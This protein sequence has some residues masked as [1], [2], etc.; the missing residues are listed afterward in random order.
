[1]SKKIV[2][3]EIWQ[4]IV[5]GEAGGTFDTTGDALP[6]TGFVV[7]GRTSSLVAPRTYEE[8]SAYIQRQPEGLVGYW[9]DSI[10]GLYHIDSCTWHVN[11]GHALGVA[12]RRAELAIYD[13]ISDQEVS[14]T[15]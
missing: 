3:E 8:L 15:H 6:T 7:G 1:M 11:R 13:V 10:S 12:R 5:K 9:K 14:V 2:T 4:G